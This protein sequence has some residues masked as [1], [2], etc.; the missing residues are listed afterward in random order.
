M[1][2]HRGPTLSLRHLLILLTAIGLLPLAALGVWNLHA[3]SE[4][5]QRSQERAML[6]LARALSSA[7][8]AELDGTVA[9]LSSMARNPALAAGDIGAFY[10]IAH[11]QAEAQAEWLAVIL[12]DADGRP[13]FRTTAPYGAAPAPVADAASL[14]QALALRRPAVGRIARGQGG[15]LAVPV[16]VPVTDG[17]GRLYALTAVVRPDRIVRVIER[18]RVPAGSVIAVL[19]GSGTVVARSRRHAETVARPASASLVRLMQRGGPENVGTTVTM[20]GDHVVGAYTRLSHYGWTVAIGAPPAPLSAGFGNGFTLYGA[21]ILLSLAVCIALASWLAARIVRGIDRLQRGAA[22]LGAGAPVA[23]APSRIREM[24]RIGQALEAT[25]R[26]RNAHEEERS[27]LLVSLRQALERQEDALA[28]ARSAGRAKDE[29]L[30]VLGHELRNPLSP[31]VA[32]L[33]LMDLRDDAAS[34]RERAIMRRQVSHLKRLVDDLLDVSRI[35]SG[36]LQVELR[37]LDLAELA[38]QTVAALSGQPVVLDAPDALWI[39]GDE[40]RLAQVLGNL[41]SNA[42]RFG[43]SATR[44]VLRAEGAQAWLSVHDNGAGM[45]PALLARVFE[46]FY[47]APQP[48]ARHT[49]GLGLGLAIVRRIVELHG[50][51]VTAHSDGLGHGSRFDVVLP[52]GSAAAAPAPA[53]AAQDG[54][55]LR[56]LLVDDN[57]D[58]VATTAALL[59]R[60]GHAVRVAHTAGHALAAAREFVP[61][62]AILDIGL[63]D[64]DGYGLATILRRKEGARLRLVALTGYGQQSDVERARAAGFDLHLTKPATLDDLRRALRVGAAA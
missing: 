3:A 43:S 2:A 15:R 46:P 13:L 25:A 26:Q 21:G 17:A 52:L 42:A 56:V 31:I 44:V 45:A 19:D 5:R 28:Q 47:Q 10:D 12:S 27:R 62:V 8:D 30:A 59:A 32:S 51:R 50:G 23:I 16:R 18:Q 1:R 37:P 61:D 36:K 22:A 57:E 14:Q 63:P 20:E 64:M 49:G 33:D 11:E 29:F 7:V 34:R 53:P 35:A 6:D 38:R 24:H 41:L 55:L 60:L 9:T 58:A 39:D 54:S 48:L 40:N 4:Y